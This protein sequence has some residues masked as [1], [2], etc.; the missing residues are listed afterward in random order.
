MDNIVRHELKNKGRSNKVNSDK[1]GTHKMQI[2]L[3]YGATK[4]NKLMRKMKKRSRN[5]Q[6]KKT[7]V[8][9]QR[10]KV[11]TKFYVKDKTNF[12]QKN[13]IAYLGKCPNEN[14][15]HDYTGETDRRIEERIMNQNKRDKNSHLP[16]HSRKMEHHHVWHKNFE[17]IGSNYSS[18]LKRKISEALFMKQLKPTL[19]KIIKNNQFS[20]IYAIHFNV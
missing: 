20:Y 8:T 4:G 1:R 13:N 11:S 7:I 9:Y 12:C 3:S 16:R 17:I 10:K 15:R 14:C 18:S 2:K 5:E 19:N 6:H